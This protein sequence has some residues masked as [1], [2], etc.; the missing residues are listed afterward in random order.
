MFFGHAAKGIL[1]FFRSG[2]EGKMLGE[3][4]IDA[5]KQE[6]SEHNPMLV[7]FF[8]DENSKISEGTYIHLAYYDGVHGMEI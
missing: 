4:T 6:S 7:T 3:K 1:G 2:L 5:T 8:Q